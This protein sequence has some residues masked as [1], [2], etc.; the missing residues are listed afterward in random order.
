[1]APE[2]DLSA[3]RVWVHLFGDKDT[4]TN[5]TRIMMKYSFIVK[6][7]L[8]KGPQSRALQRELNYDQYTSLLI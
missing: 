1:M 3:P 6:S 4:L 2:P 7:R 8:S 5:F